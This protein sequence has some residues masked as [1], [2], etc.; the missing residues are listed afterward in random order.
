ML[1]KIQKEIISGV[2]EDY[3]EL[4]SIRLSLKER[5]VDISLAVIPDEETN[6]VREMGDLSWRNTINRNYKFRL[7][8]LR[9]IEISSH[10]EVQWYRIR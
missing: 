4:K 5:T 2:L 3:S 1:T 10:K 9:K 8:G 7:S 6:N